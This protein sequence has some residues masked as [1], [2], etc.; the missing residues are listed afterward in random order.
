MGFCS[1]S[2]EDSSHCDRGLMELCDRQY[3][4]MH[5]PSLIVFVDPYSR[6]DVVKEFLQERRSSPDEFER[7]RASIGPEA[8]Q[9]LVQ[10]FTSLHHEIKHFHDLL[11]TPFGNAV[12]R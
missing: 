10:R 12:I 6:F 2:R 11:L 4:F 7:A 9:D 8:E 3:G 5:L 1:I